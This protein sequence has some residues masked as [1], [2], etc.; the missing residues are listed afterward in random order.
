VD[1]PTLVFF[2]ND[3]K[4]VH[5]T[6]ERYL[7]NRIREAYSFLGTPLR[8]VFRSRREGDHKEKKRA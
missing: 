6:Y 1:P 3:H 4:L 5:F 2:V 7:E 8:L